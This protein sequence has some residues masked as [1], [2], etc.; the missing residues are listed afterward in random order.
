MTEPTRAAGKLGRRPND[1]DK[2][3]LRLAPRLDTTVPAP[4][5]L[6][7]W[8][9]KVQ[10]WP[11]YAN[12]R[13]GDCVWAMIGHAIEAYTTY[14]KGDT[15]TISEADV[16]KSYSDVTGFNPDDPSTDQGTVI[17]D[18]LNYW[19][20]TGVGGHQIKAFAQ[21]DHTNPDEVKAALNLFGVLLVGVNFPAS[22]MDQFNAGQPW[23]VLDNDGG[24]EGG[25]AIHVGHA[26]TDN[27]TYNLV[28]WGAVEGM[29]SAWWAEYVEE[30]W[31]AVTDD[32]LSEA[33]TSPGGLDLYGLGEDLSALTGEPNPFPAPEPTPV[34][35]PT[36]TPEPP[37]PSPEPVDDLEADQ[38]FAGTLHHF[39]RNPWLYSPHHLALVARK[40]LDARGL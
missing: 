18:A 28:T 31:I 1:P 5:A 6:V 22:A 39:V 25:H 24:I 20:T 2:P 38:K 30:A 16:L 29:T 3:R 9:D 32:W 12:D 35:A 21:V 10:S 8:L 14:G 19:K 23:D 40:W 7:D 13:Y 26:D 37:A 15:V 36:P 27:V 11:M 33:G 34:P 4:P 17:Q